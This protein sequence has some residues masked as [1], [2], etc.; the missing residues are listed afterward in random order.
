MS[1]LVPEESLCSHTL[2]WL[3]QAGYLPWLCCVVCF[4]AVSRAVLN[5]C[6]LDTDLGSGAHAL[7]LMVTP[8]L[9]GLAGPPAL[10]SQ[11]QGC[12]AMVLQAYSSMAKPFSAVRVTK[13]SLQPRAQ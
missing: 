5:G 4:S 12:F 1:G 7:L 6:H 8:A 2:M 9:P 3:C 10:Q 11:S 13:P